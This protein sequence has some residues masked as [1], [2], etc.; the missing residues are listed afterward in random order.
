MKGFSSRYSPL[1]VRP[2]APATRTSRH[3]LGSI[4][5]RNHTVLGSHHMAV[6][7]RDRSAFA[8]L[9][10]WEHL[11]S[12]TPLLEHETTH[13][14]PESY[15]C[16]VFSYRL[17]GFSTFGT[18]GFHRSHLIGTAEGVFTPFHRKWIEGVYS[19]IF[20]FARASVAASFGHSNPRVFTVSSSSKS[21]SSP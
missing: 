5:A 21:S 1:R 6:R 14:T 3:I 16:V 17:G 2:A 11:E 19:T 4:P 10:P 9:V 18:I 8:Y 13:G 20:G 7:N 15:V 12:V